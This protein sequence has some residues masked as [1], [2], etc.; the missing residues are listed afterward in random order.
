MANGRIAAVAALGVFSLVAPALAQ[1]APATDAPAT[2]A[3]AVDAQA[4]ATPATTERRAAP[5]VETEAEDAMRELPKWESYGSGNDQHRLDETFFRLAQDFVATSEVGVRR[6]GHVPIW[7]RGDLKFGIV[8]ILPYLRQ[9]VEWETNLYKKNKT[10]GASSGDPGREGRQ[11]GWTH[12]NQIGALADTLL[13]GGRTRISL[14]VDSRWNV[15]YRQDQ[16]D[17]WELD[18]QIGVSHKINDAIWTSVGYAYERRSDPIEI[19]DN[20]RFKRTNNRAFIRIGANKDILLGTKMQYEIGGDFRDVRTK[21]NSLDDNTRTEKTYYGKVSYPVWR[22]TTRAFMRVTYRDD[23]RDSDRINDGDVWG[24]DA[25]IEGS[26]PIKEGGYRGLRGQVSFG[27]EAASYDDKTYRDGNQ[28]LQRDNKSR[29][30]SLRVNA[31]LQYIM[32]PR[33]TMDLRYGRNNAF[34]YYGNY[35]IIDRFDYTFTHNITPKLVGRVQT[36]WEYSNPSSGYNS[37]TYAD[38]TRPPNQT[39]QGTQT[40]GGVGIGFR[41]PVEEWMDVD[42]SFDYEKKNGYD[43]RDSF[44]NYRGVMGVTF[45]FSGFTPPS[46]PTFLDM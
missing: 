1:S 11:T 23:K 33:T 35:Q 44:T 41:Y 8:R 36:F 32:S 6:L 4:P 43:H 17:D 40:R 2:G 22:E 29:N 34:S 25:G 38:G 28:E 37:P 7:P 19:Q 3:P 39:R 13:N 15:R 9:S 21:E 14:S 20:D 18:S 12:V 10:G 27:F 24:W 26:I 45:Y 16:P 42:L 46:K 5:E 30:T 31:A